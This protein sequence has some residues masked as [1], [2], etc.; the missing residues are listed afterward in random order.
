MRKVTRLAAALALALAITAVAAAADD[1][2]LSI[3]L[4]PTVWTGDLDA[5]VAKRAIR[6]LVPYSKTL[7]FVDFGG[8]QRGI[9]YD[10]M[11]AFEDALNKR[12][13]RAQLREGRPQ[14]PS[15]S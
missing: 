14:F 4:K 7:Y 2:Q 13:G 1:G 5:L 15:P 9:S 11:R 8:T 3:E 12:L 6:V 10:F